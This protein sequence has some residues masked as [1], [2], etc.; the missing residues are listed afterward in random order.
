MLSA[1][2]FLL[3]S[4]IIIH[5]RVLLYATA[6]S[7]VVHCAPVYEL[8]TLCAP[9]EIYCPNLSHSTVKTNMSVIGGYLI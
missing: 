5:T 7:E 3:S 8:I 9:E 2:L 4:S 1:P 6:F